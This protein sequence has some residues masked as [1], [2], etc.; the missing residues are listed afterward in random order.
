M[1]LIFSCDTKRTPQTKV[2]TKR[3]SKFIKLLNKYKSISFDT[4]KVFSAEDLESNTY[5]FKGT[6][7]DSTDVALLPKDIAEQYYY[8]QGFFACYKFYI[9]TA[10][11]GLI[12]RTPSEYVPS[13]IKLFILDKRKDAIVDYT[14]LAE[15][16]GD[17]G[18]VTEKISWLFRDK[19]KMI[20]SFM[21]VE[22]SHDNSVDNEK[23]TTVEV[24]NYY[25]LFNISN[26]KVDT[27]SKDFSGLE[28]KFS[29]LFKPK[30]SH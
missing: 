18:D 26:L 21:W 29:T 7:L 27:L 6:H 25:Y 8:D 9:D 24:W 20:N 16:F 28:N 5:K 19:S 11:V 14:E 3:E 2:E 12:T 30:A 1:V 15:S 10:T 13:S 4:L 22:E 23:D 17:A